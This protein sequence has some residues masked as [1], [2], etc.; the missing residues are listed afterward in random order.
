MIRFV[1]F[2]AIVLSASFA[3][4]SFTPITLVKCETHGGW[5]VEVTQ[6]TPGGKLTL[7]NYKL[8]EVKPSPG[9]TGYKKVYSYSEPVDRLAR[10]GNAAVYIGWSTKLSIPRERPQASDFLR[11]DRNGRVIKAT[12][13]CQ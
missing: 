6:V 4:A 3:S 11:V 12:F 13:S 5:Y 1:S 2:L 7:E 8:V 9:N 10:A